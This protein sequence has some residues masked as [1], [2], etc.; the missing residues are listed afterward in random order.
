V[1]KVLLAVSRLTET[2]HRV[3]FTKIGGYIENIND[4]S[5]IPMILKRGVYIIRLRVRV[6]RGSHRELAMFSGGRRQVARP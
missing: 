3:N 5:R 6:M 2:G 4:G 1:T